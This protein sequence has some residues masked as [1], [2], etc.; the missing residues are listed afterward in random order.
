M[1]GVSSVFFTMRDG[2][3]GAE[4]R[5][6]LVIIQEFKIPMRLGGVGLGGGEP[7]AYF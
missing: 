1:E 7:L 3:K 5:G 2:G 4:L 6:G